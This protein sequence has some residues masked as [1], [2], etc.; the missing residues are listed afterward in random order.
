MRKTAIILIISAL[1]AIAG[2]LTS[3]GQGSGG[4]KDSLVRASFG[5]RPP[6]RAI[7]KTS[8]LSP[9]YW[10]IPFAGEYRVV[11]EFMVGKKQSVNLGA[12]YLTKGILMMIGQRIGGNSGVNE[13]KA[14]GYRIQGAYRVYFF[15]KM[16]RPEGLYLSVHSSFASLKFYFKDSPNDY[17]LLQHF[18]INLLI[19]GQFLIRNRVSIDLF[20]GPGYKNNSYISRARPGYDVINLDE[21]PGILHRNLKFNTGMNI[22]FAL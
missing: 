6:V 14:T 21:L 5:N 16:Y 7:L 20:F 3:W 1:F 18:N 22:G 19:G 10:Q 17:Q 8:I 4:K 11:G 12:S 13:F 2:P 9:F 15:N